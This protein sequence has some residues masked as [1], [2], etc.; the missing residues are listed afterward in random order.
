MPAPGVRV[1]AAGRCPASAGDR[2]PERRAR[3]QRQR[4]PHP[5]PRPAEQDQRRRH[6][7]QQDVL[8]HVH[9]EQLVG[10]AVDRRV[11]RDAR[12]SP[13]PRRTTQR[14]Q[15]RRRR[16]ER[17]RARRSSTAAPRAPRRRAAVRSTSPP[18]SWLQD[19]EDDE[20]EHADRDVERPEERA[21]LDPGAAAASSARTPS[22]VAG[23]PSRRARRQAGH[24]RL[25]PVHARKQREHRIQRRPADEH[26]RVAAAGRPE[27][28]RRPLD[29][30]QQRPT[31]APAAPRPCPRRASC[32][33]CVRASRSSTALATST[34]TIA[35]P[36]PAGALTAPIFQRMVGVQRAQV[37]VG[38]HERQ[39]EERSGAAQQAGGH[40][41]RA[42]LPLAWLGLDVGAVGAEASIVAYAVPPAGASGGHAAPARRRTDTGR[43]RTP[44]SGRSRAPAPASA[45]ATPA[46]S[47]ATDSLPR[48]RA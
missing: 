42:R 28:E 41:D 40:P 3:A 8:E 43:R 34:S 11:E 33:G 47:N 26:A 18:S 10:V 36:K 39:E 30:L 31:R 20:G 4:P 5:R 17:V 9:P 2:P 16:G 27:A 24:L 44:G 38:E 13:G 14:L 7:Q 37:E 21:G 23:Q 22:A 1:P 19:V 6:R 15:R 12:S 29:H 46:T 25:D 45:A 35:T 32:A 48:A